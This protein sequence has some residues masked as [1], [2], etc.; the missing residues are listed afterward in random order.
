MAPTAVSRGS[1]AGID[2]TCPSCGATIH[3]EH[4]DERA[5]LARQAFV[6]PAGIASGALSGRRRSRRSAQQL[7]CR[8]T[9]TR[10]VQLGQLLERW[11]LPKQRP[12]DFGCLTVIGRRRPM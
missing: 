9:L 4:A 2:L 3:R 8:A 11:Y 5:Q 1:S 12:H 10:T 6:G 7:D